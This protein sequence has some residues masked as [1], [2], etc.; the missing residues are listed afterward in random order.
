[1]EVFFNKER[2][3]T[4]STTT[5]YLL[6]KIRVVKPGQGE[7]NYHIFY[8]LAKA[9]SSQERKKYCVSE[10]DHYTYLNMSGCL[11]VDTIDD[12]DGSR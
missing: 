1:M 3:I 7:R 5:N 10:P 4:G 12:A 6:E 8:Q 11:E 2:Q 9:S